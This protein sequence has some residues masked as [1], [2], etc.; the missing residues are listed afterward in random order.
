MQDT[1]RQFLTSATPKD[2][3]KVSPLCDNFTLAVF[4]DGNTIGSNGKGLSLRPRPNGD[5]GVDNQ[6]KKEGNN[7]FIRPH[8]FVQSLPELQKQ[9][10]DFQRDYEELNTLRD[11]EKKMAGL[12]HMMA[13][14]H[15]EEAE[16]ARVPPFGILTLLQVVANLEKELAKISKDIGKMQHAEEELLVEVHLL[17]AYLLVGST[18]GRKSRRGEQKQLTQRI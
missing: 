13:W 11:L 17:V 4:F 5:Y 6:Q 16:K 3:Y 1:S 10:A 18:R 7:T 14:A 12:R 2:K 15:V 9:L 8:D